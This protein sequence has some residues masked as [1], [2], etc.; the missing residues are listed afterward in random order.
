MTRRGRRNEGQPLGRN[1]TSRPRANIHCAKKPA[2]CFHHR[3]G[4]I[5]FNKHKSYS[6]GVIHFHERVFDRCLHFYERVFSLSLHFYERLFRVFR[7]FMSEFEAKR[8]RLVVAPVKC[9]EAFNRCREPKTHARPTVQPAVIARIA[10][11]DLHE[12][13]A[14]P[15]IYV[16]ALGLQGKRNAR[17]GIP[18]TGRREGTRLC[19]RGGASFISARV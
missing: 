19:R 1:S 9:L 8:P 16:R 5:V 12:Q 4:F 14:C 2:R 15:N 13:N 3:A 6:P 11:V 18:I 7:I 17:D 10:A